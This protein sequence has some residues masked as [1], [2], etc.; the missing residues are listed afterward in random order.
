MDRTQITLYGIKIVGLTLILAAAFLLTVSQ[1]TRE[2]GEVLMYSIGT[3]ILMGL[4]G[5]EIFDPVEYEI[6]TSLIIFVSGLIVFLLT[7]CKERN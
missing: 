4:I 3:I 5:L 7:C 6:F 1:K 2:R